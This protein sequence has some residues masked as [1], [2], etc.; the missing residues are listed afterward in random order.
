[1]NTLA[2]SEKKSPPDN[3]LFRSRIE[4]CRILRVLMKDHGS[5]RAEIGNQRVFKSQV[6]AVNEADG[7]F[8][9]G[10]CANKSIN[11]RLLDTP[12]VQF[13]AT[14]HHDAHFSFEATAPV[15]TQI[16]GQPVIQFPLPKTLLL[17][18][19]REHPHLPVQTPVTLRC[20]SNAFEAMPFEASITDISHDGLGCLIYDYRINLKI[21]AVL[22]GNRIILPN[23][24]AVLADLELRYITT[25]TLDDGT[26]AHRAGFRFL[27][28]RG[29]L[30]K[31]AHLFIQ[32]LDKK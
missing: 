19:R 12:A 4:I 25:T 18:N 11:S 1:M 20:I 13:T 5:I 14:S 15:A 9:I 16:G 30:A 23:G 3:L 32:D 24:E 6:L 8:C 22:Q 27:Q 10:Y 31:I 2:A 28:K 7:H 29:L 26:V 21:G 17:H